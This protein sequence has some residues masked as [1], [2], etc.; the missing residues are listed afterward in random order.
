MCKVVLI[1]RYIFTVILQMIQAVNKI[2]QGCLFCRKNHIL[3]LHTSVASIGIELGKHLRYN[4]KKICIS[5]RMNL[6]DI[7]SRQAFSLSGIKAVIFD[8][9]DTLVDRKAAIVRFAALFVEQYFSKEDDIKRSQMIQTFLQIDQSNLYDHQGIF[10][11]FYRHYSLP[12]PEIDELI[13]FWDHHFAQFSHVFP[14]TYNLLDLLRQKGIK[15]VMLTNGRKTLQNSKIDAEKL[16][17]Y[18]DT[19]VISGEYGIH[20]P[21]KRIFDIVLSK[22]GLSAGECIFV[23]DD[24]VNDMVGCHGAGIPGVWINPDKAEWRWGGEPQLQIKNLNEFYEAVK[25]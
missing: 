17:G 18:F 4:G 8:L 16:R 23:G 2:L 24:P 12:M 22:S 6:F 25:L 7:Q 1:Y 21:D 5:R 10:Q 11:T 20:K 13:G 14:C 9:D 3:K 19:I 15:L